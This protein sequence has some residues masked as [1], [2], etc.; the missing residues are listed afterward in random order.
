MHPTVFVIARTP[1]VLSRLRLRLRIRALVPRKT[2]STAEGTAIEYEYTKGISKSRSISEKREACS[3]VIMIIALAMLATAAAPQ[4]R[5]M[6]P[7]G[8]S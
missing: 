1:T 5:G 6:N 7:R 2:N 4:T 8:N 3:N